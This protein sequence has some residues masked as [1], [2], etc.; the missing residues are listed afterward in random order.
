M[1]ARQRA[2]S[3]AHPARRGGVGSEATAGGIGARSVLCDEKSFAWRFLVGVLVTRHRPPRVGRSEMRATHARA[4][5][6]AAARVARARRVAR[7][8]R[9]A[10]RPLRARGDDDS[11]LGACPASVSESLA[12]AYDLAVRRALDDPFVAY[13]NTSGIVNLAECA[14]G[15]GW[16]PDDNDETP[17]DMTRDEIVHATVDE[18]S[19]VFGPDSG[20]FAE[21]APGLGPDGPGPDARA[22]AGFV[23]ARL[24][25]FQETPDWEGEAELWESMFETHGVLL[26]PGALRDAREPGWFLVCVAGRGEEALLTGIDR[27]RAQLLQ[28]KFLHGRW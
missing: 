7:T 14:A 28:R 11:G 18:L 10:A 3:S 8:R 17:P 25:P 5:P 16:A 24:T 20:V 15:D 21:P 6:R 19:R 27:L 4:C 2:F 12:A 22:H 26:A 9:A 1:E 23:R 13:E